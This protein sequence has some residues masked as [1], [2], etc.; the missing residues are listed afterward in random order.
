[1]TSRYNKDKYAYIRDL[2]NEPLVKLTSNSK[3]RKL[4]EEKANAANLPLV[5]VAPSSPTPSLEVIVATPPLTRSK[6]KSK[7]GMSLWDDY[8]IA[9][10]TILSPMMN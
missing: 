2:K 3:K 8:T 6:G 10:G 9:L 5:N 7:I 4:S 1:M